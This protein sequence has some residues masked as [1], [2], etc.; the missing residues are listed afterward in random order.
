MC[1][2]SK[3]LGNY[4][5]IMNK[6]TKQLIN[7]QIIIPREFAGLRLDQVLAKLLP[8]YSRSRLQGWL[9]DGKIWL[10]GAQKN[11]KYKVHGEEVV[12]IALELAV[13][14]TDQAQDIYFEVVYQDDDLV[15]INKPAGM[16]VHPAVGNRENTLLNALLHKIP[17]LAELPRAGIVHRLDKDTSGLMV[18]AKNIATHTYLVR[19][20]QQRHVDRQYQAIVQGQLISGGMIT[21]AIGRHARMRTKMAVV[22]EGEGKEAITHYRIIEKFHDYTLLNVKLETGRTHQIRVHLAHKGHPIVGDQLYG[23]RLILPKLASPELI[24]ELRHFKRQA[25]HAYR[26]S[27]VHP[28]T[29]ELMTWQIDLPDD[30]LRLLNILRLYNSI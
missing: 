28:A 12:E 24:D 1:V 19:E 3:K 13:E 10:N 8:Q 21:A 20:L 27:L 15:V 23:G 11:A 14:T 4:N 18:V 17:S 29:Q 9:N 2:P 22:D 26:L 5:T 25:L 30:M 7:H 16:V 6:T